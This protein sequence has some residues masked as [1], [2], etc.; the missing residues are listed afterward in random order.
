[1]GGYITR[2]MNDWI[3]KKDLQDLPSRKIANNYLQQYKDYMTIFAQDEWIIEETSKLFDMEIKE[4]SEMTYTQIYNLAKYAVQEL[5]DADPHLLEL[6][7]A[8][9][10]TSQILVNVILEALII[11]TSGNSEDDGT[12][13]N[14]S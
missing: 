13:N 3:V 10:F 1:M 9:P 7:D 2:F 5:H 6:H 8:D 11:A 4:G 12:T 14:S